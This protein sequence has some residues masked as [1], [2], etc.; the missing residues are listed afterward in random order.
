[1][2]QDDVGAVRVVRLEPFDAL[3]GIVGGLLVLARTAGERIRIG[4]AVEAV[5]ELGD[6]VWLVYGDA[7][8]GVPM[9]GN[10][11]LHSMDE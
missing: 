4:V 3:Y 1:M 8:T 7:D 10:V 6:S 11:P 9:R 2:I 5:V